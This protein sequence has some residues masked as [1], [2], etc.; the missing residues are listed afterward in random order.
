M[1]P[2]KPENDRFITLY[3]LNSPCTIVQ[4]ISNVPSEKIIWG[5]CFSL[6]TISSFPNKS[7]IN[8]SYSILN[9]IHY[10]DMHCLVCSFLKTSFAHES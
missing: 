6:V 5:T 4:K 7:I 8:I 10:Q 9:F 2:V 1:L 3:T